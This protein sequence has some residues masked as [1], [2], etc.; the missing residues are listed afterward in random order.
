MVRRHHLPH[1]EHHLA[2]MGQTVQIHL[3]QMGLLRLHPHLPSWKHYSRDRKEQY[4]PD[5]RPSSSGLGL[6]R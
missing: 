2:G 6:F 1:P 5:R 4:P 3:S